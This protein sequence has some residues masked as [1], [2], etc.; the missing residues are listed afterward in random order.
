MA[1]RIKLRSFASNQMPVATR[2]GDM[3]TVVTSTGWCIPVE[4]K[5]PTTH[6]Q[7][8]GLL[9]LAHA[10]EL[11][12]HLW[13]SR[14]VKVAMDNS[15]VAYAVNRGNSADEWMQS[16]LEIIAHSSRELLDI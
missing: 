7:Y 8:R 1:T 12:G 13:T 9:P 4:D 14:V 2:R 3:C 16:L 6:I 5:L 15:T 10:S 11:L